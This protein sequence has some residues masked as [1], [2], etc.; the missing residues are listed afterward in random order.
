MFVASI[1]NSAIG[2]LTWHNSTD[3]TIKID[4]CEVKPTHRKQGVLKELMLYAFSTFEDQGIQA[5]ELQCAPASSEVVWKK[6]GFMDFPATNGRTNWDSGNKR[7]YKTV[8]PGSEFFSGN[9]DAETI[10]LWNDEPYRTQHT[11]ANWLWKLDFIENTRQLR[12]PIIH[13][14]L[15]DWKIRWKRG[16]TVIKE[17]K[18]KYFLKDIVHGNFLILRS[19]PLP[20]DRD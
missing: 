16:G 18:A 14:C 20:T 17:D 1:H 11:P 12:N 3:L 5:V 6:L 15:S 9:P 8:F 13:P 4:I 10:E 19:L 2:F 7:L